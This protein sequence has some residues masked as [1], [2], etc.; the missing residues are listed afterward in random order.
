MIIPARNAASYLGRA[1]ES[2]RNQTYS[3]IAEVVVAAA[4]ESTAAVAESYGAIVVDNPGGRTPVAL[5][6]AIAKTT[7]EVILRCDAQS[8]LPPEYTARAVETLQRTKAANVG[9]MQVPMGQTFWE[10]AIVWAMGSPLGAGDAR[11]RVGGEEGPVE[12]VYLG[13][14]KRSA[15]DR[16]DG[17]DEAFTRTQ[18]YEL[19][20]RIR[21]SGGLVWFDPDL[22]VEYRP[23]GSLSALARQYFHYGKAK[24]QFDRKHPG[25]LQ[26]RQLVPPAVVLAL[27][28]SLLVSIFW[29]P[30]LI[31]PLGYLTLLTVAGLDAVRQIGLPGLGSPLALATMHLAW[32]VGFL[33]R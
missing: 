29:T 8:V 1:L 18:D 24:R 26:W 31:V 7:G 5:N 17:F 10:R 27:A 30:A 28:L 21:Q 2:I 13:V 3:N 16:I 20:H 22:K 25:S 15:L 33:S 9:G 12:T 11:Y 32:G 23:R 6:L 14:F 19:N 4:D